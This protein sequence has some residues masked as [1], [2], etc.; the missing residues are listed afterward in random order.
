MAGLAAY[1]D[2]SSG[3][4]VLGVPEASILLQV[5]I[6]GP[7]PNQA[8]RQLALPTQTHRENRSE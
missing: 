7:F 2:I 4:I 1:V 6:Q 5:E 3:A 8:T